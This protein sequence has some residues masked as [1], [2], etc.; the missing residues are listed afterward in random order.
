MYGRILH[1]GWVRKER[2]TETTL[3]EVS[4]FRQNEEKAVPML[5]N[6]CIKLLREATFLVGNIHPYNFK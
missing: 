3:Y 6:I 1:W 5:F 2:Q 4:A